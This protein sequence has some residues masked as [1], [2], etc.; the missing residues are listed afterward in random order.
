MK[1]VG[2]GGEVL[3]RFLTEWGE[4]ARWSRA[5]GHR[6]WFGL[7]RGPCRET[8][9]VGPAAGAGPRER[10]W[11]GDIEAIPRGVATRTRQVD[12]GLGTVPTECEPGDRLRDETQI[13]DVATGPSQAGG[14]AGVEI[15]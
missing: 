4:I 8:S 9:Q 15:G 7:R 3:G 2:Q 13:E 14:E 10:A 1:Q 12:H 11:G 6:G 5:F